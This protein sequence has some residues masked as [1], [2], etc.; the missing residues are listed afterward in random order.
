MSDRYVEDGSYIRIQNVSLGYRIPAKYLAKAKISSARVY[1]TVQNLKTFT[2][3]SG[4]DPEVGVFNNNIRLMNVDAGHYPN[5]R[6]FTMGINLE[7]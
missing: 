4:Y 1:V 7:L 3:Y 5:P 6:S 2:K